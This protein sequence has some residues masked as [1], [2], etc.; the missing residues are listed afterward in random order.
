MRSVPH[1]PYVLHCSAFTTTLSLKF[2]APAGVPNANLA[3][4]NVCAGVYVKAG[5]NSEC[6]IFPGYTFYKGR[7]VG[8]YDLR[9]VAGFTSG[10]MQNALA[11]Y[12][13]CLLTPGRWAPTPVTENCS[14]DVLACYCPYFTN[15]VCWNL[16]VHAH[17]QSVSHEHCPG[18]F[19]VLRD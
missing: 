16:H 12:R 9:Q 10:A 13:E 3:N 6:P 4:A 18:M 14:Y 11:L 19:P 2:Y 1:A 8:G 5:A 15:L 17:A 7:D